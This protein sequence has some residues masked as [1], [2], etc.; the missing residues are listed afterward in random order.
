MDT[1]ETRPV[2]RDRMTVDLPDMDV[3][4]VRVERF[5]VEQNDLANLMEGIKHGRGTRPGRYTSLTVDGRL[6]MTDTDAEKRDHRGAVKAI[7]VYRAER[8]LINGLGLGMVLNAALS[9]D[10]VTHVD[11]VEIDDRVAEHIGGCYAED[12]RVAIHVADVY[13]QARRWA[14]NTRWD[15]AW[16][17]IWP[18]LCTDNLSGMATLR[19]S[20]GS[21]TKWHDCW[22]REPL[23][24]RRRKNSS[25][26]W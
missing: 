13:E 16:S 15:V 6:W 25:P 10:H 1:R 18:D 14:P 7:E 21:R 24:A 8:V 22:G 12:P 19:R 26:R 11:V 4:G 23:L 5:T 3:D 20:Y 17:D 2:L 9:F